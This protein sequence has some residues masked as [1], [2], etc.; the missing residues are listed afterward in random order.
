MAGGAERAALV[1]GRSVARI[2][3][4]AGADAADR[5]LRQGVSGKEPVVDRGIEG[6]D[7][8][9]QVGLG[10]GEGGFARLDAFELGEDVATTAPK[11]AKLKKRQLPGDLAKREPGGFAALA[12]V[13][14]GAHC[15][16]AKL[17]SQRFARKRSSPSRTAESIAAKG[18]YRSNI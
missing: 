9:Q 1:G 16:P 10:A 6:E 13:D 5:R 12:E 3:E 17:F 18:G 14:A 2:E 15:S 7:V 11:H 8:A 4:A